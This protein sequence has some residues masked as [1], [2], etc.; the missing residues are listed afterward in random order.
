MKK[1][2]P[3]ICLLYLFAAPAWA[4]FPNIETVDDT[5]G[6]VGFA[7]PPKVAERQ[8]VIK[9][10]PV[11]L[12]IGQIP[13]CG[14]LRI[15]YERAITRH[16]S[17]LVGFSYSYPGIVLALASAMDTL[18]FKVSD[19]SINGF[20]GMLGYRWYPLKKK[21]EAP[22]GFFVGPYAS[23]NVVTIKLRNGNG[24]RENLHYANISLVTGYQ[25]VKKNGFTF[26]FFGGLGYKN[27][28]I[29]GYNA[30]S[31][32]YISAQPLNTVG[33]PGVPAFI[34]NVKLTLQINMGYAF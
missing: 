24:S 20:R 16:H 21:K 26:E 15:T 19:Y 23:Y 27:N 17:V 8:N 1:L 2:L 13:F 14:E 31:N 25:I 30:N 7:K 5:T 34:N 18:G 11:P 3:L 10:S 29:T 22:A 9:T 32:R 28:F 33:G 4:Q 6:F 12:L